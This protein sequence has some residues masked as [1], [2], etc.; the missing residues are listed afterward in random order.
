MFQSIA[1][2][3]DLCEA[4]ILLTKGATRRKYKAHRKACFDAIAEAN[5]ADGLDK[6]TDEQL[7]AE[8]LA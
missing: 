5:R 8:L 4:G 3:L 7:L 2:D 6:L 1:H